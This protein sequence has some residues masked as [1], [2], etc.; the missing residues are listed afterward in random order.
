MGMT[1]VST[2]ILRFSLCLWMCLSI[3]C[4]QPSPE[5]EELFS[6]VKQT[7]LEWS[8]TPAKAWSE[9]RMK[10]GS[11][12][13]HPVNQACSSKSGPRTLWSGWISQKDAGGHT[14]FLDLTFAQEDEASSQLSPLLVFVQE[15]PRPIRRFSSMNE[16]NLLELR[17]P[18]PFHETASLPDKQNLNV[19]QGL[20]LGRRLQKGLHLGFSYSGPCLFIASIRLYYWKCPGFVEH[21]ASFERA[22]GG[23]ELVSGAC[24]ENS[25]E[26]SPPRRECNTN[27][28]WGPLQGQCDCLPGHQE[29]RELCVACRAGTYKSAIGSGGCSPCPPNSKTDGEGAVEC[30]CMLGYSRVSGDP[31]E[32]GCSK[33][34]SSPQKVRVNRVSDSSLEL[35]W[36]PPFDLGGRAEVWYDVQCWETEQDSGEEWQPCGDAV[37]FYPNRRKLSDTAVNVTG[38][39]PRVDYRLSVEAAN[40]IS[41]VQGRAG[42]A[43]SVTI[44]RWKYDVI[45]TPAPPKEDP[46]SVCRAGTYK[47]AN[48]S[49]GCSPCPPNSRTDGEDAVEC[50]CMRGFSRVSGDPTEMGCTKPP[51]SPQKVR[52]HRVSDSS[53]ELR[54]DP[55]FDLGGRAEVWYD[56]QCWET[57]QDSGEEWQPCGDA[58]R[59]YPN[60]RKL[61]DTAVSVTGVDPRT[62]YR[63][64]VEAA[65]AISAVQGRAG[66]AESVNIHRWKYDV[67]HT[68]APP[69]ED[70][71]SVCRAGTYKSANGSGGCS[72]CPPNSRTDGEDAVECECMR[73]YSR[74]SGDP[75]EMGCTKP[76]SSPQ[77]V[78]V[79]RV[80]DSSLELRWD[81]PFDLG[82]RAEVWYDV[83]CWETEQYSGEEWQPCGDAVRFYPNRRKLSDTAV[84]VTGVDPRTDYRLSVE[85]ANA[86]SAV[87]GRAGSAES[88][89]IH[90][91]KPDV[92]HTP[93]PPAHIK[94]DS[95]P[96]WIL[97]GGIG[98]GALLL[99]LVI[100]GVCYKRRSYAKLSPDLELALLPTTTQMIYRRSEQ[101]DITPGPQPIS[102][103]QLLEG[104]CGRLQTSLRDM[105]VDRG[106]LTVG[107]PLGVGE[108]G[109]VYEGAF[110]PQEG[111]DIKVAVKTMKVGIHSQDDLDSFLKEAEIMQGF[112]HD[113]VVKLLGVTLEQ[114]QDA[115]V[116]TP[117]LILP[118]MKHGDLRR[119]LIAT[120]YNDVPMFVPYQSL[121]RFMIDIAA[122][123]QYLS[124]HSF[125]HRDLAARNCMLGDDLRVSVADFGLSKKIC[126]TDYYRQNAAVR[127][128]IKWMAIESLSESIYSVK[129]DVW[130]FGVTMWEIATRGRT[131]YP[132]VHNHE[133]LDLLESGHRLKQLDFEQDLYKVMLSCWSR[134]PV[135]RPGFGELGEKLKAILSKLPPLEASE[136][137]HYIN[138]GL[139]MA[140]QMTPEEEDREF[141]EGAT[142]NIY[143]AGPVAVS[144][145]MEEEDGYLLWRNNQTEKTC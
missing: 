45:H 140:S 92:I 27:G 76:P 77:K 7:K 44:H 122:G 126:S 6:T 105:L 64:S 74:V 119:F 136:E 101:H 2:A 85:A 124:S 114:E 135:Q 115:S 72:P 84:N 98:G 58:V 142:G 75:T 80:S 108:F 10:L 86:I 79:H 30:E 5:E 127:M 31:T 73:G 24:V 20:P 131:P 104:L 145:P 138:Q 63:L 90:R 129:S 107:K 93:A 94:D 91:W 54:W 83:Q 69:K 103:G 38:V 57:E 21:Q 32:M 134:D 144:P 65:N 59:F 97:A 41:A 52:V 19:N 28:F 106:C 118:F 51:S 111:D 81:P 88:V 100:T 11:E 116:P 117:M 62:D 95:L 47:S 46:P 125:V 14:L 29:A 99:I 112:D 141:E 67:I 35:R 43:E 34:P 4:E 23:S 8:S 42:S 3:T 70:P 78:R 50:E 109:S 143:L 55:P 37:R 120:R 16:I 87:Q 60:R 121:L 48:G 89:N 96:V 49:G 39:D 132:G 13:E 9:V 128:P 26:I 17:A 110:A 130:S 22:D 36:D 123:M 53:L 68:P 71:P 1:A 102:T 18:H 15:S 139:V 33:P 61:S 113:N 137:V 56:V 40:A 82:G 25:V 133:L 66:S 12:T